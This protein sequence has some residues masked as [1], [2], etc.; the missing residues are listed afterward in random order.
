M[1][2]DWFL[3]IRDWVP[4]GMGSEGVTLPFLVGALGHKTGT[5]RLDSSNVVA[6]LDEMINRPVDDYVTEVMWC[7]NIKAPVFRTRRLDSRERLKPACVIRD[8]T[9]QK[10]VLVFSEN[11]RVVLKS[12]DSSV[13][14]D[15]LVV[16]AN[17]PVSQGKYSRN[18]KSGTFMEYEYGAYTQ[19]DLQ[20]IEKTIRNSSC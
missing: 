12:N 14:L 4:S 15:R 20:Y 7:G 18:R 6:L 10:E 17:E 2:P 13:L 8:T 1:N 11:I 3:L 19:R 16:N 5:T 9:G